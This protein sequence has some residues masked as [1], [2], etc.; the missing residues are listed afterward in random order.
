MLSLDPLEQ[1]MVRQVRIEKWVAG[2]LA[3][4]QELTQHRALY[5]PNEVLLMLRAAGFRQ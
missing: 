1:A 2:E 5:L 4:V 3:G